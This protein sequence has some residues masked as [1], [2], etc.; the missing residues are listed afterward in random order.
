MNPFPNEIKK[1]EADPA[2]TYVLTLVKNGELVSITY[3]ALKPTDPADA[4]RQAT[5]LR[6]A[7]R[8]ALE[9]ATSE[10]EYAGYLQGT[11]PS[12]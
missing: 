3:G 7:A 5:N 10:A 9:V 12:E 11:V 6:V 4:K 2:I 8:E 1:I